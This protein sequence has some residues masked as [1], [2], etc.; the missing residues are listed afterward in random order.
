[1]KDNLFWLVVCLDLGLLFFNGFFPRLSDELILVWL[2]DILSLTQLTRN[3]CFGFWTKFS[4][5]GFDG[6]PSV[7]SNEIDS[8]LDAFF[9]I[10]LFMLLIG[11]FE[12]KLK[13]N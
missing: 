1:M 4:R 8:L 10:L 3:I 11:Y 6:E 13:D 7:D 9:I 5:R 2:K 12:L